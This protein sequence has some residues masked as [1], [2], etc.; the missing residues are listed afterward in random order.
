MLCYP[1]SDTKAALYSL[2]E[3]SNDDY[4]VQVTYCNPE[5]GQHAQ[6]ILGFYAMMLKPGQSIDLPARSPAQVFHQIEGSVEMQVES[7][8]FSLME[9]DTA[10]SPGYSGVALRNLS[11]SKPA[12]IFIAD[13][14]PLHQKLGVYES[15]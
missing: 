12:F 13:E 4:P 1:W 15:R 11:D 7:Q 9:A 3:V 2:A 5:T 6:N 14:S 10:V 8:K